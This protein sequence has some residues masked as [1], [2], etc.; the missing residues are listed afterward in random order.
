[1]KRGNKVEKFV[2]IFEAYEKKS[3]SNGMSVR[4]ENGKGDFCWERS[5]GD[6][7]GDQNYL[8]ASVTKLFATT[9]ILNLIKEGKLSIED[10]ISKY[11][12]KDYMDKLHVY[13]GID[14]SN[15][16]TIKHL[17]TQTS[18]LPDYYSE[19]VKGEMSG[20]ELLKHDRI[21]TLVERVRQIKVLPAKFAPGSKKRSYYS[22]ANWDLLQPIIENVSQMS[23]TECYHKY[24]ILPLSLTDTYLFTEG[25]EFSFPGVWIEDGIYKMPKLLLGWPLSGSI[26]SSNRDMIAFLKAFYGG[27]LFPIDF[28]QKNNTYFY[29]QYIPMEY[30]LGNMR[31]RY[32]GVPHLFGHSGATG[33]V[34][35]Y[36]PKYDM[37]ISACI[38]E[39]N[40]TKATQ[41]L[42][43]FAHNF[44]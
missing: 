9:V 18:G 32:P 17:M 33:V 12:P 8:I 27:R 42:G 3:K 14:Y 43:I 39:L 23:I 26:V 36:A 28:F 15:Q 22:D 5:C 7:E 2:K 31:F 20:E 6:L 16:L 38:N 21:L 24:I 19:S 40:E 41:M 44:R 11:L 10:K 29:T 1:M 35:Y 37:Y 13:K 25:M 34:C 4:I 30:G